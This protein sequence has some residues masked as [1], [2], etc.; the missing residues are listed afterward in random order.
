VGVALSWVGGLGGL[1]WPQRFAARVVAGAGAAATA[2]RAI[3]QG[4]S[5]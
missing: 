2:L 1:W 4:F 5:L 3:A